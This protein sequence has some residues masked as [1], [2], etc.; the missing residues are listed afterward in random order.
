MVKNRLDR[1]NGHTPYYRVHGKEC[2][3]KCYEF[4]EKIMYR[5]N[6]DHKKIDK[7]KPYHEEGLYLTMHPKGNVHIVYDPKL[8]VAL[9]G[10]S[11]KTL[12]EED[13][14]DK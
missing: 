14:W 12:P 5:V 11:I 4:C 10:S 9:T 7:L 8:R 13:K 1:K 3:E 2:H 6:V